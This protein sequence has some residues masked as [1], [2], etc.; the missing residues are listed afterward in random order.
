MSSVVQMCEE[1]DEE[2]RRIAR[3]PGERDEEGEEKGSSL[4]VLQR[5]LN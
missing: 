1:E 3:M 4:E 5:K 2:D